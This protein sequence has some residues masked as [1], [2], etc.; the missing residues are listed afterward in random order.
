MRTTLALTPVILAVAT[1]A[2]ADLTL[3][4]TM[5]TRSAGGG[6]EGTSVTYYKGAKIRTDS[7]IRGQTT[8]IIIDLDART[9]VSVNHATKTAARHDMG[10]YLASVR[11]AMTT[12]ELTPTGEK[13]T[14]VNQP[15]GGYSLRVTAVAFSSRPG[16]KTRTVM[17]GTAWIAGQGP[18]RADYAAFYRTAVE[19]GLFFTDPRTVRAQPGV[20][21]GLAALYK[22]MAD[23]GVPYALDT[24]FIIEN[25]APPDD[26]VLLQQPLPHGA[27]GVPGD[28]AISSS[29]AVTKIAADPVPDS[30]FEVPEGYRVGAV[31]VKK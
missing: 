5:T 9:L 22:A 28:R 4:S 30:V 29:I 25:L 21:K 13:R 23:E 14:L 18:G 19:K 8:T 24:T 6:V 3:S 11:D 26:N 27:P 2:W 7:T 15:C 17:S 20:A 31:E 16:W 12:V 1:S 10:H